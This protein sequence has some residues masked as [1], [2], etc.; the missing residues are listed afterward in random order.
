MEVSQHSKYFCEFCGKVNLS[1]ALSITCVVFRMV[2][3]LLVVQL[4]CLMLYDKCFWHLARL[5]LAY[6]L[7]VH[8][9]IGYLLLLFMMM[10]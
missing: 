4:C 7:S 9:G 1:M 5:K 10:V 3:C 2:K 6:Y 8:N